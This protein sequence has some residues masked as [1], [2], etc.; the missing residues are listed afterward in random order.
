MHLF[1]KWFGMN[2]F[3]QLNSFVLKDGRV[4]FTQKTPWNSKYAFS[5]VSIY[6]QNLVEKDRNPFQLRKAF[7]KSQLGR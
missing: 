7:L 6:F 3:V 2:V 4:D 1:Q 5:G